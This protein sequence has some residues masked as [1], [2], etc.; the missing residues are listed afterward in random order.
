MTI[1]KNFMSRHVP[2]RDVAF[3][4]VFFVTRYDR[5]AARDGV[6]SAHVSHRTRT[7]A[8]PLQM[9]SGVSCVSSASLTKFNIFF[10]S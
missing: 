3:N 8:A 2:C 7:D 1:F 10:I 5:D 9:I 6:R 4:I